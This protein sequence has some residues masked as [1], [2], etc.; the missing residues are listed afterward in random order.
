MFTSNNRFSETSPP[1][2]SSP[3]HKNQLS[4]INTNSISSLNKSL[5]DRKSSSE[6]VENNQ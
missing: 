3:V 5:Q 2:P 6:N 1:P 4:E